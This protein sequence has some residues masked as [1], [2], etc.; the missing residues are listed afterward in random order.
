[1]LM[2]CNIVLVTAI[3]SLTARAVVGIPIVPE[4]E[5]KIVKSRGYAQ[6]AGVTFYERGLS[7]S[8]AAKAEEA[9]RKAE[10][11]RAQRIAKL[12]AEN[13]ERNRV[14]NKQ[15]RAKAKQRAELK[16]ME[17]ELA[18]EERAKK[19]QRSRDAP[20]NKAERQEKIAR[21][22][23]DAPQNPGKPQGARKKNTRV[24][25]KDPISDIYAQTGGSGSN[26]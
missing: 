6:A 2:L 3:L 19:E 24:G 18:M 20:K 23:M 13:D 1:M 22:P 26:H 4:F 25:W 16:R 5:S 11:A 8:K 9:K 17:Q 14:W 12:K 7:N 15:E 10:E 21:P